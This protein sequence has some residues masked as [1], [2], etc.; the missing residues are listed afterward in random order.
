M[1]AKDLRWTGERLVTSLSGDIVWEHLHRYAFAKELAL[2]KDVLD[3]ACG[4]GYGSVLLASRARSVT[5][6]DLSLEATRHAQGKYVKANLHFCVGDCRNI[7]LLPQSVDL[8]VSFETLEHVAEHELF[9]A[10]IRRVLRPGG[11]LVISSPDRENYSDITGHENPFHAKELYR[12][13]F[14]ALTRKFFRNN[15]LLSQRVVL[16]SYLAPAAQPELAYCG[17][18]RGDWSGIDFIPG[19]AA[20]V[21]SLAVCSDEP[22][23]PLRVGLFEFG[24]F[25][26]DLFITPLMLE[27]HLAKRTKQKLEELQR[28][29]PQK[30]NP[31]QHKE[32]EFSSRQAETERWLQEVQSLRL[33]LE[34]ERRS[35]KAARRLK[36]FGRKLRRSMGKRHAEAGAL[37]LR[38]AVR[39]HW[40][41]ATKR[42]R[43]ES[44]L[45]RTSHL[46]DEGWYRHNYRERLTSKTDVVL[47]YLVSGAAQGLC[48]NE[49]FN[50]TW[51]LEENPDVKA[52]AI[53]PL[54]HYIQAGW[55][56]GREPNLHF[57]PR[58]YL[59]ANPDVAAAGVEPLA[60]YLRAGIKEKRPLEPGE[61]EEFSTLPEDSS[62]W[63]APDV[64]LIAFYLPQFHRIPEN[65]AWWGEGFT[66]WTNV[67]R[68]KPQFPEHYQPHVPHSAVGQYDLTDDSVLERQV[69]MARRFGIYGFCFHHYWFGGKRL[70]E[71]PVE[72]LLRTGRPDFPFCVC[73]A[74]ENWTRRWDGDDREVLMEQRHTPETDELFIH[75]LLPAL[76]DKRYIRVKGQPILIVYRPLLLPEPVATF[77]RWRRICRAQGVRELFLAGVQG[78]GFADP[79]A[80]GMDAVIEFPPHIPDLEPVP[81][82]KYEARNRFQGLLLDF[83]QARSIILSRRT[84][85]PFP[86]FRG[87]MPSW[88]NTAR[89][90]E[91]S[92]IFVNATPQNYYRWLQPIV[93][94]TRTRYQSDERLVFINAWNEWAEGC[95]LE[96][97]ER[98][99]FAWL[100]AT[101]RALLPGDCFAT[102]GATGTEL[103]VTV[104]NGS[105]Y[106]LVIAHDACRAGSQNLLLTLLREWNRSRPF[107]FRLI[108]VGDGVLR[109]QF[110]A[111]CP[112]LVLADLPEPTRRKAMLDRFLATP[113][114]II[115]SNTVVNGRIL[116]ELHY[117]QRPVVTHVHELQKAIEQ[118]APREIMAATLRCSDQFIAVS[119]PVAQNLQA[120]HGVRPE[121]ITTINAFIETTQPET[122]TADSFRQE[123]GVTPKEV[124]VFG[125]GTTDWRKGPDLFLETAARASAL[126]VRLRF[127]WIGGGSPRERT[128]LDKQLSDR[129]LQD[130]FRFLGELTDPK[131]YFTAGDIFF[132]SSREDPFPLVALEAAHAGLP[133]VCFAG[134]GGIP[135]FV[136]TDCGK[137]VPFED[138]NAAAAAIVEF[139]QNEQLRRRCGGCA[140]AK[141]ARRH[142]APRAAEHIADLLD[143]FRRT[144]HPGRVEA[145]TDDPLV[146][147]IVPNY[148][149]AR[150]L[151]ERLN[152]ILKQEVQN[153]EILLL[154]DASDDHSL[155][156]L[157]DF[158]RQDPRA[159]VLANECNS[160]SAFK[161]WKRALSQARG[162]YVW[163]AESD[164]SA[165]PGLLRTLLQSLESDSELVLAYV[166]SRMIDEEGN[167]LGLPLAWTDDISAKRW[168]ADY[169]NDGKAEIW[170]ALTVKNTIPNASAVVF[171]SIPGLAELVDESMTL[172]ADWLFWVRLCHRGSIAYS[173]RPLNLWRQN[174]SHARTRLPG[175]LEWEEGRIVI[176]T[177]A[178]LSGMDAEQT[179][180][181]LGAFEQRCRNWLL[182]A[183]RRQFSSHRQP[184]PALSALP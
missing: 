31:T 149:H 39:L 37:I 34:K 17:T 29:G 163:I 50:T 110:E 75:D 21:Y 103:R 101:R 63:P 28:A 109:S 126:D 2:G 44:K 128:A 106:V 139:A 157:E 178:E 154:D 45:I 130:R 56:E 182:E 134:A 73:W 121:A 74:N 43:Q 135:A 30:G 80:L 159:R 86:L 88:D 64:R 68:G 61:V 3:I 69:E 170:Q 125:C 13:E 105:P 84:P 179:K 140:K 4:E 145:P 95:H 172:C 118:W 67:R 100:N 65:D 151:P 1:E 177:A 89:R 141:V 27:R 107:L 47:H 18:Y 146:S 20:N 143:R 137:V 116:E 155:S 108:L 24:N 119:E 158:A 9:L 117:L 131:P 91:Q 173:S 6:V 70:L 168:R 23:P 81:N 77:E 122:R 142:A 71:M 162:R 176:Q 104:A 164:D 133:I 136:E 181:R 57:C 153:I 53:N 144:P 150:F 115:Y 38:A 79:R 97:D 52:A 87:V 54:V 175:E 32:G 19:V 166:E 11:T 180:E 147:V 90:Q 85:R 129:N 156:L 72:R 48:P 96:P 184:E 138:I 123:L 33:E 127:F 183:Q 51:Y 152:S 41:K 36:E 12:E 7:P 112:T 171:R 94:E 55:K 15:T 66:E 22:L 165:T 120:R 8:V 132:L 113:P 99:G 25:D 16:G 62:H 161:Q 76:R 35:F 60:H 78:F 148:N 59:R 93:R 26:R 82:Q 102:A 5:G 46:F 174:T 58:A 160:G 49:V 92:T 169:K 111:L 114:E 167:D 98:H 40:S 42:L 124:V 83:E 10:E 14:N